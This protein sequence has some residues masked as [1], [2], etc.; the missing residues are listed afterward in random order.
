M[1]VLKL[2]FE[3][4]KEI[5]RLYDQTA[6][7]HYDKRYKDIQVEKYKLAMETLL[8]GFNKIGNP[9]LHLDLSSKTTII[10]IGCGTGLFTR[11]LE[12]KGARATIIGL[13]LSL[14]MLATARTTRLGTHLVHATADSLP[15]RGGIATGVVSFTVLQNLDA[16]Q[17]DTFLSRL[18]VLLDGSRGVFCILTYLDKPPLS[19]ATGHVVRLLKATFHDVMVAARETPT[20]EDKIIVAMEF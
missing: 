15:I 18:N 7:E 6:A 1:P 12:E 4:S 11:F 13:D 10:D 16:V 20:T 19:D 3:K 8:A 14:K 5:E 2:T 9:L 17:Q